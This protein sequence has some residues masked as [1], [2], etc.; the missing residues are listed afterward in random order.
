MSCNIYN[1]QLATPHIKQHYLTFVK[2]EC[3]IA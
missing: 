1:A 3:I 2:S